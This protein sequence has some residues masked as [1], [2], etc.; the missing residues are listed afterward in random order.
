MEQ[1]QPYSGYSEPVSRWRDM[2]VFY[3]TASRC[4]QNWVIDQ[5]VKI[6][7]FLHSP[8]LKVSAAQESTNS[9]V[10]QAIGAGLQGPVPALRGLGNA[11]SGG[12]DAC[13]SRS[14]RSL[15]TCSQDDTLEVAS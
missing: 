9:S 12:I 13:A 4:G 5:I 15:A 10:S 6:V 11:D 8:H 14:L 3:K 7:P 1:A 2:A